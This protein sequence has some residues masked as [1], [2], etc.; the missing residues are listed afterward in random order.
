MAQF[1]TGEYPHLNEIAVE[2]V[3]APGYDYGDEFGYGL[4]LILDGLER[5][6]GRS[7]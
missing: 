1:S 2:H 7:T 4:D 5:E 6:R 3:M